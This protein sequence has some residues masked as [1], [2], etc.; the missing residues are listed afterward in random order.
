[1]GS[2][3]NRANME[4]E[5]RSQS[6]ITGTKRWWEAFLINA[7][8]LPQTQ[9][10]ADIARTGQESAKRWHCM[11]RQTSQGRICPPLQ[12]WANKRKNLQQP[13]D[14]SHVGSEFL[15]MLRIPLNQEVM[16]GFVRLHGLV[17][18]IAVVFAV[19]CVDIAAT[20][21]QRPDRLQGSDP[22]GQM[23]GRFPSRGALLDVRAD[24]GTRVWT[25]AVGE[26]A[27]KTSSIPA[28]PKA[29]ADR[30]NGVG[31]QDRFLVEEHA[32]VL[33]T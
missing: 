33:L 19:H 31:A 14:H 21:D 16:D 25:H 23:E 29:T 4:D 5:N 18:R 12:R 22:R 7:E 20:T 2:T 8:I 6:F 24:G 15:G 10:S 17:E 28:A 1:M 27:A 26:A 11:F 3:P 32:C 9:K 30:K 13:Q